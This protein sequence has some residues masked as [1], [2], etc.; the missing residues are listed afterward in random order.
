M[1]RKHHAKQRLEDYIFGI[2]NG[3]V[4]GKQGG[5]IPPKYEDKIPEVGRSPGGAGWPQF[6]PAF[7][8]LGRGEPGRRLFRKMRTR[9]RQGRC[10]EVRTLSAI[11]RGFS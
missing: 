1:Q 8:R 5:M 2:R 7:R 9:V 6:R 3:L 4:L 10:R 11:P